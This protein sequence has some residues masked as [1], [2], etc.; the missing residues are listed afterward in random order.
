MRVSVRDFADKNYSLLCVLMSDATA[1]FAAN[2]TFP[3]FPPQ[4]GTPPSTSSLSL[5]SPFPK[6][7]NM[8]FFSLNCNLKHKTSTVI[9]TI[10]E[11]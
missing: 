10:N 11:I 8:V 9:I 7:I 6:I 3:L 4:A 1:G 2:Q 5:G